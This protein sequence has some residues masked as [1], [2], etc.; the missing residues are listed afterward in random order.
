[1]DPMSSVG[2]TQMQINIKCETTK[3]QCA[4]NQQSNKL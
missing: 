1:M 4:T 2:D 3:P